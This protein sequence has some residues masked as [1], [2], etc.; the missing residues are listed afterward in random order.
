MIR[1]KLIQ[2]GAGNIGRS[3]VGQLFSAAG[4]EVVFVDVNAEIVRLLDERRGYRVVVKREG[5]DDRII[6]V[7]NIRAVSGKDHEA[8]AREIADASLVATSVGQGALRHVFPVIAKGIIAR[9]RENPGA[10]L[11]IVIAENVREGAAWFARELGSLLPPDIELGTAGG[12]VGLVET[13]I[14][15]M[16][17]TMRPEDLAIDP[18]WVF[19]EEYDQLIVDARGFAGAIPDVPGLKPVAEIRAY[20]DRKLFIHNLGH[21]AAAYLGYRAHP[22]RTLI[23]DALDDPEILAAVRTAMR[24]SAAALA[25][26]YPREF[27]SDGLESHIGE[28]LNR[29]GNRAL[30]DTVF[31]VG[32]DLARKLG[33]E[34]RL[35][36]AILLAQRHGLEWSAIARAARAAFDFRATG[37]DAAMLPSDA[38]LLELAARSGI[39]A[40]LREVSGLDPRKEDEKAILSGIARS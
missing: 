20:V 18:L 27:D 16:V 26:E 15:K 39:E 4:Y 36:G 23:R 22:E 21:A 3:F 13:S 2:F 34:D 7:A 6:E 32:R 33:R 24:Q 9:Q 12:R 5:R 38:A 8:V 17:P 37:P 28:L 11:D 40:A 14:G 25:A 1:E 10:P 35:I 29:F 31:R 30:G 19:A